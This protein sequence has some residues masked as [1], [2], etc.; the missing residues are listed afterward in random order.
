[1]FFAPNV[2]GHPDNYIEAN[3]LVTPAHIVPEWYL[4][5]FY[6]ILRAIPSKLGGVI[7]MFAAIFIL[8]LLPW[9]DTCKVRS[10]TFR[11]IYKKFFWLL[12]FV[13]ILLGYLG[14]KPPEG[15]YLV[16]SRLATA[17]YFIHFLILLPFLGRYEKTDPLPQS[18]SDPVLDK[19]GVLDKVKVALSKY[20][21][22]NVKSFK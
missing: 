3:P 20:E 19:P 4:L 15:I 11:P 1:V 7:F 12:L 14:A 9:L 6:A 17:Y 5:P 18:I 10:A 16:L 13:V 8:V 2:L 21:G 22:E